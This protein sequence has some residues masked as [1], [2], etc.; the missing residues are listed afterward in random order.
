MVVPFSRL[1]LWMVFAV[2][3]AVAL[4]GYYGTLGVRYWVTADQVRTLRSES[5][6][7]SKTVPERPPSLELLT[8]DLRAEEGRLSLLRSKFAHRETDELTATLATIAGRSALALVS[9][10]AGE[11]TRTVTEQVQYV[12]QPVAITIRGDQMAIYGFLLELQ[13]TV[14]AVAVL[15]FRI[16]GL[17]GVASAKVDLQ[18][19]MDPEPPPDQ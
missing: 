7:L 3:V 19:Y 12:S 11:S 6:N 4:T 9:I 18:F 17:G 15:S 16:T 13:R 14:P 1:K 8:A 5:L 2:L 10:S